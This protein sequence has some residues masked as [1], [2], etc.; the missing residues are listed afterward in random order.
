MAQVVVQAAGPIASVS[1]ENLEHTLAILSI[2]DHLTLK[3]SGGASNPRVATAD[4]RYMVTGKAGKYEVVMQPHQSPYHGQIVDQRRIAIVPTLEHA[5]LCIREFDTLQ[6][7][8]AEMQGIDTSAALQ[9]TAPVM[10]PAQIQQVAK[11][12]AQAEA[13]QPTPPVT[14]P[15]T[16]AEAHPNFNACVVGLNKLRIPRPYAKELVTAAVSALGRDAKIEDIIQHCLHAN[17]VMAAQIATANQIH[18]ATVNNTSGAPNP[19][20]VAQVVVMPSNA[21]LNNASGSVVPRP[22]AMG[23]GYPNSIPS[24]PVQTATKSMW[25]PSSDQL[26]VMNTL[27]RFNQYMSKIK[28]PNGGEGVGVTLVNALGYTIQQTGPSRFRVYGMNKAL[29]SVTDNEQQA[30]DDIFRAHFKR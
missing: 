1:R 30:C 19:S 14:S 29:V 21:G 5:Q 22:P 28:L 4:K 18:V 11:Q 6:R 24:A 9:A 25:T 26:V 27:I 3:M 8:L 13:Q 2:K 17:Q 20:G 15:K 10:A 23:L 16:P 12:V 7:R